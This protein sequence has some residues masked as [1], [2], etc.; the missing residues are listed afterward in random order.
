MEEVKIQHQFDFPAW[1]M[2]Q[3]DKF[4]L[5][6]DGG[7]YTDY[8]KANLRLILRKRGLRN[9]ALDDENM[10]QIDSYMTDLL[11]QNVVDYSGPLA[12][13]KR[14]CYQFNERRV[15]VTRSPHI[16]KANPSVEFPMIRNIIDQM[17]NGED[18]DQ[19]LYIYG[20]LKIGRECLLKSNPIPGHALVL[21]GPRNAGKNLIQDLATKI[22]GG[23][24]ARPY[25]YMIGKSEFNSELFH[26]EHLMIA[27]EVPFSD[28]QSRRIFG[29]KIKDFCVNSSQSCHGKHKEALTLNPLWRLS[30]SVNEEPENLVM[31]PP[32]EDSIEDKILLLKVSR[33]QMPMES[34]SPQKKKDFWN[35]LCAELPGFVH[36]LDNYEIQEKYKDSRFGLKAFQHPDLVEV[37]KEMSHEIRLLELIDIIVVPDHS[38][39]KGTKEELETALLEDRTYKRQVERLLYYPNALQTYLRRLAKARPNQVRNVKGHGGKRFWEIMS[40]NSK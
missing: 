29:S 9:R 25:R 14:G 21:A 15:L 12:G 6:N 16:I 38:I 28:M 26:A 10:S 3:S 2:S 20:W 22:M 30:I 23:R 32:L 27:D 1:Y 39:W 8:N 33:A 18:I 36:F 24:M 34:N 5:Q 7:N 13:Y 31:L 40:S 35:A 11:Y 19:R 17:F 37:L 4:Y